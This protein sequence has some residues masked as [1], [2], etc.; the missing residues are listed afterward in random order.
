MTLFV[1]IADPAL[2]TFTWNNAGHPPALLARADGTIETLEPTGLVLG[3]L[4]E[5]S[6]PATAPL[7]MSSGDVLLLYT[8]GATEAQDPQ[9]EMLGEDGLADVLTGLRERDPV[10]ILDGVRASLV[11]WTGARRLRRRPD[12]RRPQAA[13]G[14]VRSDVLA[15][16]GRPAAFSTA[17]LHAGA[18][19]PSLEVAG[20]RRRSRRPPSSRRGSMRPGSSWGRGHLPP[21]RTRT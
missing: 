7:V 5:T 12:P 3:V 21:R 10:A 11:A 19:R 4:P 18:F 17:N 2:G 1:G 9:G 15:Q 14:A 8:D 13:R 6:Y 20:R 16:P